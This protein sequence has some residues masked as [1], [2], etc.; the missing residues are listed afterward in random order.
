[1]SAEE[2]DNIVERCRAKLLEALPEI[3]D[4]VLERAKA[5]D[6]ECAKL[7]LQLESGMNLD[8]DED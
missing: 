3:V 1:M 5:G 7:I 4:A 8:D 6:P 2:M